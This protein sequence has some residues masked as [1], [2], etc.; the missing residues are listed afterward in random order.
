[1]EA[2]GRS[3]G[4]TSGSKPPKAISK[5]IQVSLTSSRNSQSSFSRG[6]KGFV[7]GVKGI[8]SSGSKKLSRKIPRKLILLDR[9]PSL[10][11]PNTSKANFK[12]TEATRIPSKQSPLT[13]GLKTFAA[14]GAYPMF[15]G[16]GFLGWVKSIFGKK[17]KQLRPTSESS[18]KALVKRKIELQPVSRRAVGPYHLRAN[19]RRAVGPYRLSFFEKEGLRD[20][21]RNLLLELHEKYVSVNQFDRVMFAVLS[22]PILGLVAGAVFG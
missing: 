20:L 2:Q 18:S 16:M 7:S 13:Q 12:N 11:K 21:T 1:L 15:I 4:R 17:P 6:V 10:S 19:S 22:A 3:I 14:G 5:P 9:A 8:A